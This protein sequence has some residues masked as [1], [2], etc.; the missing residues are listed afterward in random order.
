MKI[1]LAGG[2]TGGSV[3]PI[4]AVAQEI[5][6]HKPQTSF[7]FVGTR[8]GPEKNMVSD[9]GILF[10]SIPAAKFR[11][12]MSVRNL[13]DIFVFLFSLVSAWIIV[14]RLRPDVVFGVGSFVQVPVCWI[15]KLYRIKI[16][17]HQQD[18]R[19]GLANKLV[20]PLADQI[21]TAF[22]YT[23]KS[24][25][26]GTGFEKKMKS[27]AEWV[28]NPFR[29]ELLE[30]KPVDR[31][32]FNLHDKLPILLILGGA[33]G[34]AQINKVVEESLPE[35]LKAHQI[36]HQTGRRKKIDFEHPDYHQYDLIPFNKY[37]SALKLADIVLS[38]AGLSTITE[39]SVLGKISVVVPMSGT[40]Q[41]DNALILKYTSSAVVLG[42]E[43]FNPDD[44]PRI[45][46]SLKFN[47][48]HQN[49]LKQKISMLFPKDAASKIAKIIIKQA[50]GAR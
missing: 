26:S 2:G 6:K 1:L 8:N 42:A 40:H 32:F 43:E 17:I 44:L 50:N 41:E 13:I 3:T 37:V 46:T 47:L 20:S 35:L 21:T 36:I 4:L 33:T 5:K 30:D 28:G 22:E 14:R 12:Y 31:N 9:F 19:P 25:Y 11:R 45:I 29:N 10:R 39:L 34:A 38:R 7:L 49:L 16:V 23:A 15:A 48:A 27:G 18:A 24:F